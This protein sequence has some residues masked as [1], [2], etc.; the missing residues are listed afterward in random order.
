MKMKVRLYCSRLGVS[1]R[2]VK[3]GSVFTLLIVHMV[4]SLVVEL[5]VLRSL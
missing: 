2:L 4:D 1:E 3:F 5:S